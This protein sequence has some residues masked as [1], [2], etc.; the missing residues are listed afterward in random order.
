MS[1]EQ[2]AR[3]AVAAVGGAVQG[4][5]AGGVLLVA[6]EKRLALQKQ[7]TNLRVAHLRSDMQ[8]RPAHLVEVV[9]RDELVML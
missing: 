9:C 1:G 3:R 8:G 7:A 6:P 2:R 4:R 5:S